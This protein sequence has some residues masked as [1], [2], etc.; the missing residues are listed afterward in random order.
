MNQTTSLI[1]RHWLPLVGLNTIIL[2]ATVAAAIY[3]KLSY[4]P[5]WKANAQLNLP[6]QSTELKTSLG[7]LGNLEDRGLGFSK[8]VNPLQIQL[9]IITSDIVLERVR[10]E[11]PEGDR[12]LSNLNSYKKLFEVTPEDLSTILS[13]EV[14]AGS[15]ELAQQ[16]LLTIIEVYQQRL[17]ELRRHD[18]EVRAQF[19]QSELEQ[20]Q[21][22]LKEVQA[23]LT[24]F[25]KSTA[26]VSSEEQTKGLINAIN[27]LKTNY[28]TVV[29]EGQAQT[30]QAREIASQLGLTSQQAMNSLRLAEYKEYQAIRD[31]LSQVETDLAETR[32]LYT[33]ASPQV[34]TLL[35]QQQELQQ[36][37]SQKMNTVL[38]GL[39]TTQ[40][41]KTLGGNEGRD[42]R[43]EMITELISAQSAAEG[44]Q[45]QAAQIQEQVNQLSGGLNYLSANQ[46]QLSDLQRRYEIAES[47]YKSIIAQ[48][49][50]AKASPFDVYPNVQLV[51]APTLGTKSPD[52]S[53]PLI[54]F[55]GVL[56]AIFGSMALLLYLESRNPLLSSKDLKQLQLPVLVSISRLRHPDQLW[57]LEANAEI[58]F[59]RL[60]TAVSSLNLENRRL[61]VTSAMF[62]EG[63]T[64]ITLGLAMAWVK[65][66][67][68]VLLV[69]G[70]LR[71]AELSRRLGYP[72][73]ALLEN[74]SVSIYP[75]LDLIPALSL[76]R[77]EIPTFV[78]RGGLNRH[79]SSIQE[80]GH[81]DYVLVDSA[82]LSLTSETVMM[83]A[84]VPNILFV[85]RPGVSD[86]YAVLD[87]LEQLER[88][89]ARISGLVVNG[90]E[91]RTEGY[92]YG[93]NQELVEAEV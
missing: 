51:D 4:K 38:P 17:N 10:A 33:E 24:Q 56:T 16:R 86:R 62:G 55:G 30:A 18:A 27:T 12:Y 50:K 40:L 5:I 77:E 53:L 84:A 39:E 22:N 81:Y 28:A 36:Q 92:R 35:E 54:T 67:F 83:T 61:M 57:N 60:A 69:D 32:G 26:I 1:R 23:E 48:I 3:A 72:Q 8:D 59:Q 71:Q 20:A 2:A 11:D 25:Q 58:E 64:T 85:V 46:S 73:R 75:G 66:G 90:V 43:I 63:K 78:A 37:L 79:L 13:L 68:R 93:Y 14:E 42:S 91:S 89:Q 44:L 70:D 15:S 76:P 65:L 47:T 88:H 21:A 19:V 9:A 34:Q 80:S 52:P 6:I 41:D 45:Q 87:S 7:T 31:K 29:A 74:N 49:Q 82:P